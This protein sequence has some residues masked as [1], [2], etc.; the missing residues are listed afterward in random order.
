M[1]FWNL[2]VVALSLADSD[3]ARWTA[4]SCIKSLS[5]A[6]YS[7]YQRRISCAQA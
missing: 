7:R 5:G 4:S 1:Q 2:I 6:K 3:T